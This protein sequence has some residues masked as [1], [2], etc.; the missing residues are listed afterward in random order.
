V[1]LR[2]FAPALAGALLLAGCGSSSALDDAAVPVSTASSPPSA[3]AESGAPAT[4]AASSEASATAPATREA[5]PTSRTLEILIGTQTGRGS[6]T[7]D[8]G[9]IACPGVAWGG[10]TGGSPAM[11]VNIDVSAGDGGCA[12]AAQWLAQRVQAVVGTNGTT[13]MSGPS[14][15]TYAFSGSLSIDG[16]PFTVAIGQSADGTWWIGG[17]D[18]SSPTMGRYV[19]TNQVW[20]GTGLVM[21]EIVADGGSQFTVTD[22]AIVDC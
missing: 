11:T 1:I 8:S 16:N 4:V 21:Y 15:L 2:S 3:S 14:Q 5:A 20:N 12:E 18:W 6:F 19:C 17:M 7:W 13:N 9:Y 10:V 22:G